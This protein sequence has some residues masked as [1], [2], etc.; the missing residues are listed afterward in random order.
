MIRY[1]KFHTLSLVLEEISINH[2]AFYD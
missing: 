2:I 1:K